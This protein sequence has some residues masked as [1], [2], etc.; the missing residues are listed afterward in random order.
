MKPIQLMWIK[1]RICYYS[2]TPLGMYCIDD[3]FYKYTPND[4]LSPTIIE[5]NRNVD[6]LM[7]YAQ[8]HFDSLVMA[9]LCDN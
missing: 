3:K 2:V 6:E 5:D 4:G 8:K 1:K 7:E 9:L